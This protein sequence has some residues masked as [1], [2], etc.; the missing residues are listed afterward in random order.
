MET[1][2]DHG[3]DTRY[4]DIPFETVV[5]AFEK[6]AGNLSLCAKALGIDRRTLDR[7]RKRYPELNTMMLDVE[8]GLLDLTESRLM[9]SINEGNLTAII[10]YLKTKGKQRGYIEGQL[11][12]ANI[13]TNKTMTQEEAI[14][15]IKS[16]EEEY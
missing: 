10:F 7:W 13:N 8:E 12:S 5:K 14:G 9:Q 2:K 15:F 11:I 4:H 1:N 6:S 16:L 3:E